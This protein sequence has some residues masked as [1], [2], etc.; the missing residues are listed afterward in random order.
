MVVEAALILSSLAIALGCVLVVRRR[1]RRLAA[2]LGRGDLAALL[3]LARHDLRRPPPV[4]PADDLLVGALRRRLDALPPPALVEL[5]DA[6]L[7]SR[8]P[9]APMVFAEIYAALE[10]RRRR[11]QEHRARL[12]SW[13][14]L[15]L[16]LDGSTAASPSTAAAALDLERAAE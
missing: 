12:A 16:A 3:A 8:H 11:D 13:R 10:Q 2:I 5:G 1:D 15:C 9:L 4:P 6:A 14:A 7:A